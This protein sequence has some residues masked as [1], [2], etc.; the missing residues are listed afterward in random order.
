MAAKDDLPVLPFPKREDWAA[1]LDENHASLD[2]I[3][4]KFAKKA[5]GIPTI[6]YEESRDVALCYGWID[7]QSKSLDETW[8]LQRFTPR[9]AR[10]VWS[11]INVAKAERADR[12]RRDEAGRPGR[13]RAREGGRSLGRRV[14]LAEH[15]EGAG[16]SRARPSR[17]NRKAKASFDALDSQNR[18]AILHRLQTAKKPETRARRIEQFVAMLA[19][20]ET[21]HPTKRKP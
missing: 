15:G 2:G 14:R 1:W 4:V 8:Y 10:S 9:R 6:T 20:G 17:K 5:S 16:R 21:I 19:E 3:W 18:Y 7:G 13:D 12:G 11:K